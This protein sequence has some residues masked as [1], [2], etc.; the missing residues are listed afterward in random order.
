[1]PVSYST[2]KAASEPEAIAE[3]LTTRVLGPVMP[4]VVVK[5]VRPKS[6]R[7]YEAPRVLWNVYEAELEFSGGIPATSLIWTK[8]FF[9]DE[10]SEEYQHRI[11]RLLAGQNGNPLDP[12]GYVQFFSDLNLFLFFFPTDPV[13]PKMASVF[14][15]QHVAPMLASAAIN[16]ATAEQRTHASVP[17]NC[18]L[19]WSEIRCSKPTPATPIPR[20]IGRCA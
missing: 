2:I 7:R 8:A 10:G 3:L 17:V 12:H 18:S 5:K 11:R 14:D 15:P 20:N 19:F 9:T 16:T 4:S 1:M 6:G 13:F